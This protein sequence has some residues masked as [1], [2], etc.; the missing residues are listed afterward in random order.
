MSERRKSI[1]KRLSGTFTNIF[2][3]KK[4][5]EEE[6]DIEKFESKDHLSDEE[7]EGGNATC[8][9][10]W[11]PYKKVFLMCTECDK[12]RELTEEEKKKQ[13]GKKK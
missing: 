11:R 2:S 3:K 13:S 7:E 6:F 9:H 8:S 10:Q 4:P 5:E 1:G 12:V